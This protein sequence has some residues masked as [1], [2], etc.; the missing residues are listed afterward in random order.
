MEKQMAP[1]L[2]RGAISAQSLVSMANKSP[3]M[4][5]FGVLAISIL[6]ETFSGYAYYFYIEI[7]GLAMTMAAVIRMVNT[8]W[9]SVNDP[10]FAFLSDN[11]RSRWG[12]RHAWLIPGMLLEAVVFILFFSVP[13]AIRGT[14]N[15]FW[16]MLVTV[17]L[18]ET[19]TTILVVNYVALFP[20]YFHGL[21][22]RSSASVHYQAG[23]IIAVFIGLTLTP[24][25]YRAIGFTGMAIAYTILSIGLLTL[26]LLGNREDPQMQA[27]DQVELL[28]A[29]KNV[30]SDASVWKFGITITLVLF[31]VNMVPFTLPF[32]VKHALGAPP[33]LASLLSG[34]ALVASL[35]VL[36]V[37][38]KLVQKWKMKATFLLVIL[39]MSV[40]TVMMS[41]PPH[42]AIVIAGIVFIGA[43]WGGTW[44]CNNII[45]ADLVSQNLA[46]TGKHTEALYYAMLN[47]IQNMGGILQ[48]VAMILTSRLFGYVSGENPGPQPAMAFRFLMGFVPLF[49]LAISWLSAR[50][51][52][53]DYPEGSGVNPG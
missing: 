25:V 18:F 16:Y 20:E 5:G 9:S 23:K 50:S 19:L 1:T 36:P 27:A 42:R 10:I 46:N 32:Y 2:D 14:T 21:K 44:V 4:Y 6:L 29:L 24:L 26:A 3:L 30:F 11:T 40:G 52:F 13:G 8:L 17:L 12:R 34:A 51:F 39:M 7:L 22:Q 47:V 31:G 28:P 49:G 37:W 43:A 33:E 15:L 48:S 45:R 35:L 53:T 38:G 41:L